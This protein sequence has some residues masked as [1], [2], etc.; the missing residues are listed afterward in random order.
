MAVETTIFANPI[1]D[2]MNSLHK[3]LIWSVIW[4]VG[5]PLVAYA[6]YDFPRL[7]TL[8]YIVGAIATALCVFVAVGQMSMGTRYSRNKTAI[9]TW[10]S[11]AISAHGSSSHSPRSSPPVAADVHVLS[12]TG[13]SEPEVRA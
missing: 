3:S 10:T 12:H 13:P 6:V 9:E 5:L 2:A 7:A 4:A 11:R 8:G 1:G